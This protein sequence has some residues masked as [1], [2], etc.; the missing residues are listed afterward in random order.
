[1][2]FTSLW[3][4][5]KTLEQENELVRI[6]EFVDPVLEIAE[7]TDR[8]SKLPGGGKALL[9]EN[10]GTELPVLTNAIG[11]YK[12]ICL[13]LGTNDLD[14]FGI[15]INDLFRKMSSNKKSFTDKLK[16]LPVL[17]K[18][19]SWMPNSVSGRGKCQEVILHEPDLSILPILK[20]WPAD[21]GRFVTL[22]LV[23]TIDPNTGIRNLGMYRMQV[24]GKN[25]T[26]MH[27]HRHKT[28]ARHYEEYKKLGRKMPVAVALGGDPVYT[29]AATAPLPDQ[30]DEYMLAGFLRKKRVDLVKCITQDIEVPCDADI[31]IEGFVD[32]QEDLVWEGPFGDHTGFYSLED[33][34]PKF[35]VTCIT[36]RR[37]AVY[38]ATIV[39]VPPQEDAWIAKATERIFLEP[40]KFSLAPEIIDLDMPPAGVAHNLVLLKIE[41]RYP[42]QGLKVINSL[43][44]AGQMMFNKVMVVTDESVDIHDYKTLFRH[45][46]KNV[47]IPDDL[48]FS[49]GPLDV[50]DHASDRF[51]HGGKL[52]I[53]IT[54]KFPE[55]MNAN[56]SLTPL[57]IPEMLKGIANIPDISEIS[58]VL[59][60]DGMPVLLFSM[61]DYTRDKILRTFEELSKAEELSEVKLLVCFNKGVNLNDHELCIWFALNNIDPVRDCSIVRRSGQKS[62]CLCVDATSK[63][64]QTHQFRRPWPN[65]VSSSSETIQQID[66]NWDQYFVEKIIPSPSLNYQYLST[67][68]QATAFENKQ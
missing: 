44:G 16:L 61:K 58:T 62:N 22:P 3:S 23:H 63:T 64:D 38:P 43:W 2:P 55:E 1:M 52:G 17:N 12:R 19:G 57:D 8:F 42:G 24:F 13:A 37:S 21:G 47:S 20:C 65:V 7:I 56:H 28:G 5:I 4:F 46:M 15:Q 34:Y 35:H 14:D 31:V 11:S 59:A 50:L 45:I 25:V 39:G 18:I 54:R 6:R 32:P 51:A 26:G 29:Y 68:L 36:H 40:M 66:K 10:T 67:G 53:D 49:K 48:M 9:F 30:M 27:W 60:K 41:K 33:W